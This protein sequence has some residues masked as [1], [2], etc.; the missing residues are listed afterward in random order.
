LRG[1][2][3][4]ELEL[5]ELPPQPF[6]HRETSRKVQKVERRLQNLML[7]A[8]LLQKLVTDAGNPA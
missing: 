7:K 3:L 1:T 4:G 5:L 2:E 8:P 6:K